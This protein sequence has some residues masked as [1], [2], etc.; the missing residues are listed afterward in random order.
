MLV[1]PFFRY[2]KSIYSKARLP[3]IARK[4][5]VNFRFVALQVVQQAYF[6]TSLVRSLSLYA[7]TGVL[8][9]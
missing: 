4:T 1:H 3:D 5:S 8:T 2:Q 6:F 9:K 7:K